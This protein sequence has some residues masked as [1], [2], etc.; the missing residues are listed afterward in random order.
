MSDSSI[1]DSVSRSL[2][3]DDIAF[4]DRILQDLFGLGLKLEY[5][6]T[7]MEDTPAQARTGIEGVVSGLDNLAEPIRNEIHRLARSRK[8]T[9]EIKR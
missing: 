5:C 2:A 6:L 8:L 4:L 1:S 7:V 9:K 3:E